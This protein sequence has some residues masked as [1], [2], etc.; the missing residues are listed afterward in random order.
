MR[1]AALAAP[2]WSLLALAAA[3]AFAGAGE[4]M[5]R[6]FQEEDQIYP[7]ER[8]QEYVR[9]IGERL[10]AH[11]RDRGREYHF[12]VL[13]GE[14]INAFTPG[15]GYVFISRGLLAY[16]QSED[17]L[18]AVIG[19]EIGH[20]LE[21]HVGKMKATNLAGKAL[22]IVAA[23]ATQRPELQ[24]D[25]ADPFTSLL[26]TG[27]GRERELD[28]D[29]IGAELLAKA[30][31]DPNAIIDVVWVMKDQQLFS[32][33]VAGKQ[34][35]YHGLFAS[36]PRNDLRLHEA[37]N[38]ARSFQAPQAADPVG[39][40]WALVDGLAYGDEA[41]GGLVRDGNFYH[42]GLRIVLRLPEDWSATV[43]RSQVRAKAPGGSGDGAVTL[44]Y[45]AK[46]RRASPRGFVTDVLKRADL[47]GGEELEIGGQPAFIG[48]LESGDSDLALQLIGVLY[49]GKRAYLFKG[50]CGPDAD[51]EQFRREF[52]EMLEGLRAMTA[53]DVQHANTRRVRVR[54][55]EPGLTY[56]DLAK[57]SALPEHAEQTLRLLNADYP[58]GEPRPGD[59]VKVVE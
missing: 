46:P 38:Y 7:D 5:L 2:L 26:I 18:A 6:E 21:R 57:Q 27:H 15:G 23:I 49:R 1:F 3:P 17:Q 25:V 45:H 53:Q 56:A 54:I 47:I 14:T 8:W 42:T 22:G 48:E 19:H 36:H 43:G 30:G 50:R 11:S 13:E 4:K 9:A 41:A 55:A 29:R 39:D 34:V 44:A 35:P 52:R 37:V 12:Y 10:L 32:K 40:F 59:P 24:R 58:N 28:A 33:Q 20:V 51:V 16:M 31:Y